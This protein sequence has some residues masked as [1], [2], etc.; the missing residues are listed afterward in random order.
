MYGVRVGKIFFSRSKWDLIGSLDH[1][2]LVTT[3]ITNMFIRTHTMKWFNRKLFHSVFTMNGV[4]RRPHV[5]YKLCNAGL[6][7]TSWH[8]SAMFRHCQDKDEQI[9]FTLL[10]TETISQVWCV[11]WR[12]SRVTCDTS[13]RLM[14]VVCSN[15]LRSRILPLTPH[16]SLAT[17]RSVNTE[18]QLGQRW[19]D[20]TESGQS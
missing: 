12:L 16:P 6:R 18:A 11:V 15:H 17:P 10:M 20:N 5:C 14:S 8:V 9:Q 19:A 2:H 13:G 1:C 4:V 7:D 3:C